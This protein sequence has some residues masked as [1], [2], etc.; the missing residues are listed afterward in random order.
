MRLR[1]GAA[2]LSCDYCGG[3]FVPEK[4]QDGARLLG[5]TSTLPCPLCVVPLERALI[6]HH[7]ILY[8]ARC[9][10]S[11]I[12]MPVFVSLVEDL[13]SQ[14]KGA[15]EIPHA[16]DPQ[17]LRRKIRCPKCNQAMDTHYYAGPGNVIIDDCSRCE[18][19]WLD[20]GELT[21]IARAPGHS[22][23]SASSW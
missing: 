5:E 10:G 15:S 6:G 17:R 9:C 16:P 23:E 3:I 19:N 22:L 11:L 8:C 14:Q 20:H 2:S 18:L 21:A 13:R 7:A 12:A 1:E 4:N